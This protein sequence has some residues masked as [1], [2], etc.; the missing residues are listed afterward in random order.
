MVLAPA[1]RSASRSRSAQRRL[2]AGYGVDPTN[3]CLLPELAPG[4]LELFG[5]LVI[6]RDELGPWLDDAREAH[7]GRGGGVLV[8]EQAGGDAGERGAAYQAGLGRFRHRD[9]QAE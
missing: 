8:G 9:R 3:R 7:Q 2:L 4:R 6:E 1:R 5:Q